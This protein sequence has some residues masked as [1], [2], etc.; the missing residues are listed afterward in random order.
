[1]P[2]KSGIIQTIDTKENTLLEEKPYK[3]D[4]I[5]S[6]ITQTEFQID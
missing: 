6:T 3:L 5:F 2:F 4:E 1:M